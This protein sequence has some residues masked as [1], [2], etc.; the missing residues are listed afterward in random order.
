MSTS[1]KITS[2]KPLLNIEVYSLNVR[3][4]SRPFSNRRETAKLNVEDAIKISTFCYILN[5]NH[6]PNLAV[7]ENA[8]MLG[9]A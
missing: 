9:R 4:L 1:V 7:L 8:L 6:P 5:S 2:H 3:L